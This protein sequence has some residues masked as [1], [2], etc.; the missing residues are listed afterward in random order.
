MGLWG[1]LIVLES[2]GKI[3]SSIRV[4][5]AQNRIYLFIHLQLA[6]YKFVKKTNK[7]KTPIC[8]KENYSINK[9]KTA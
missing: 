7:K 1:V 2:C 4:G 9:G 5:P 3:G 8:I 6:N